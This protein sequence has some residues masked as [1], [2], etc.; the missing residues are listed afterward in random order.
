MPENVML[1]KPPNG[2]VMEVKVAIFDFGVSKVVYA[3]LAV[4]MN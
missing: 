2:G 4:M 1:L 3:M